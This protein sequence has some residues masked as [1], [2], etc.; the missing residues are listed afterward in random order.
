[1]QL[2]KAANQEEQNVILA[3]AYLLPAM[4]ELDNKIIH[5]SELSTS[6]IHPLM[7]GLFAVNKENII[8]RCANIAI[9]DNDEK[10]RP[11]YTVELY[12]GYEHYSVSCVGEIKPANAS[13]TSL[14]EDFYRLNLFSAETINAGLPA[15]MLFQVYG[16]RHIVTLALFIY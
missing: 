2:A 1:M 3:I 13:S 7:Q 15:T 12:K 6:Y 10:K 11:D 14:V 8:A 4:K 5:E 16:K 9:S